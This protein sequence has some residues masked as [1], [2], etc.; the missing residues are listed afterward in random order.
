[1][2]VQLPKIAA[3]A[4]LPAPPPVGSLQF[5][6]GYYPALPA[7]SEGYT[8]SVTHTM[9]GNPGVPPKFQVTQTVRVQGPEFTIDPD[10]VQTIYPPNGGSDQ[11]EQ[12][13]PFV[14]LTDPSLPWE[15]N[16]I[17]DSGLPNP[18]N[19]TPWMAL[20]IFAEGEIYLQP[21]SNNPV[22]SVTVEQLLAPDS[23]VL[24]PQLPAN[25]VSSDVMKS[26]CQAITI[27][28]AVFNAVVPTTTELPYLAH[29]RGVNT[30]DEGEVLL[31]VLLCNRLPQVAA[32]PAAPVHYFAQLVSLE[33]WAAYMGPNAK[34]IP[35]KPN[36][37]QLMDVQMVSLFHWVFT[38]L[39]ETGLSFSALV[40]GLIASEQP[41]ATQQKTAV[42][43]LPVP[44]S[45]TAPAVVQNRLNE[46][47]VALSFI[48]GAGED[49][50][51]WYR[52]P[53][54]A[55]VPQPVSAVG[56]PPAPVSQAAN[57]D[58]L[59][60]Y[61]AEQGLF[62]LSY[63]AAWNIGRNLALADAAFAQN[64]SAYRQ[65]LM[66]SAARLAQRRAM[67]H[68]SAHLPARTLLARDA[69]RRRFAVLV[70]DGLGETWTNALAAVRAGASP[71][72]P[73]RARSTVSPANGCLIH[74][75]FWQHCHR[76]ARPSVKI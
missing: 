59:M 49:T 66:G 5:F 43:Q 64:V 39:P 55:A 30:L 10:I 73:L 56:N 69:T 21:G 3:L 65:S 60:I 52:G 8:L 75:R 34:P 61:L 51:A 12:K 68:F 16:L 74:G 40:S 20:L 76:P 11:Y 72:L 32:R 25:W 44:P 24:K 48:S 35:T 33:G 63:A 14:V 29:C 23:N 31:S 45:T 71:P 9:S 6:D 7:N 27:P 47:Y 4:N 26:Q 46:G 62:D 41:S 37:S 17:P 2:P 22:S 50:F 67:V 18:G 28:G 13:L 1:M 15:R 54:T 36:S 19:P 58:A 57:A 70:G 42:L 38:C 53:F